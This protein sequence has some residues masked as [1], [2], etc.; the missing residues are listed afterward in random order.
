MS[1]VGE[2]KPY[3]KYRASKARRMAEGNGE[4]NKNAETGC[5][6]QDREGDG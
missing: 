4:G 6:V 2:E 3:K 5:E 1:D